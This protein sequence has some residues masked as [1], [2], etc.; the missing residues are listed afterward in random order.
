MLFYFSPGMYDASG[1]VF[2]M[3]KEDQ[4][5]SVSI[6]H[7]VERLNKQVSSSFSRLFIL[8]M[9]EEGGIPSSLPVSEKLPVLVTDI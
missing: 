4:P 1:D 9:T 6:R 3:F 7:F 5:I 2:C 8:R